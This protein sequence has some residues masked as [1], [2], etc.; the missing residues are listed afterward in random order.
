[1]NDNKLP[2]IPAELLEALDKLFPEQSYSIGMNNEEYIFKGGQRS[3]IRFLQSKF[4]EQNSNILD[5][6]LL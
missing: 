3:V 6:E 4:E 5:R 2:V 1:M